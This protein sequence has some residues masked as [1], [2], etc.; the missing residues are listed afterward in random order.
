MIDL[1][2][3]I[4]AK[5][6]Q[7]LLFL[8]EAAL[9]NSGGLPPVSIAN[10][11]KVPRLAAV[12][13]ATLVA[14]LLHCALFFWFITRPAPLPFSAAAPL[15]MID[16]VLSAPVAPAMNQPVVP[17]TPVPPRDTKKPDPKPVKKP[18]PKPK[19]IRQE[20][21]VKQL[22]TQ[23]E[24]EPE[25]ATAA[26]SAPMADNHNRA[27]S[28]R[29]DTYSP[30]NSNA[31]YLNNPKPIYPLIARQ[32]HW[33]GQVLLRVYITVDGH[34][35]Q[36]SVQRSSGH[37]ELDESALEAVKNW[38]FVPAKRG[39]FAEASWATVPIEFELD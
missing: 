16:M 1:R 30:A 28:P 17:L 37:E 27:A 25:S 15:P 20:T 31:N 32:R 5:L 22:D 10:T 29:N 19:P 8:S 12:A 39:D 23:Q 7:R 6:N 11:R 2:H 24:E 33:Q 18:K 34:C 21:A 38:R 3:S 13:S 26:A 35:G 4:L 14:A 9:N 36:L